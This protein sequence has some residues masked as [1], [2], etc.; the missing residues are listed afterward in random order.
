[1]KNTKVLR[2]E[3]IFKDQSSCAKILEGKTTAALILIS[4]LDYKLNR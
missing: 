1:M 2:S 4:A 3:T